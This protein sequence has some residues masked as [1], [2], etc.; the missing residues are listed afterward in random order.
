MKKKITKWLGLVLYFTDVARQAWFY[1]P[2]ME[3]AMGHDFT[4]DADGTREHWTGVNE[5]TFI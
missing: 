2:V 4:R 1:E 3:A 5:G